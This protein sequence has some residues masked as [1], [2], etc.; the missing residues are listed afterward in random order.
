MTAATD[1]DH[2]HPLA[3]ETMV[4]IEGKSPSPRTRQENEDAELQIPRRESRDVPDVQI[5]LMGQLDRGFVSW[6]EGELRGRGLKSE[7]MFLSPR[8]SLE[9]VI[10]RQI[11]RVYTRYPNSI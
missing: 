5:I 3:R 2:D 4:G 8:L 6:V 1:V 11:L 7:V 10:R 9:A